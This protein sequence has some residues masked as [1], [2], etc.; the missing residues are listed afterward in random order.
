MFGMKKIRKCKTTL[1][2][3]IVNRKIKL[4]NKFCL[5]KNMIERIIQDN[6]K[7]IS[8]QFLQNYFDRIS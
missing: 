2:I 4:F 5:K 3:L 6:L 8:Y 1:T 7:I